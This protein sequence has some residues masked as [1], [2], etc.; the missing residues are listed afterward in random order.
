MPENNQSKKKKKTVLFR[1]S[2]TQDGKELH[3]S[4]IRYEDKRKPNIERITLI[5]QLLIDAME[6]AELKLHAKKPQ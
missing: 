1:L 2:F 3:A 6:P 4:E 5:Q